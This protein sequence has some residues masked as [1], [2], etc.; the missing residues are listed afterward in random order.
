VFLHEL[1]HAT[2]AWLTCGKVTGM[3]VHP[4]EGGV[5]KTMGGIQ[6][7]ILPAVS[8]SINLQIFKEIF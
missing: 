2:A 6:L 5:T 7:I 1:G 3:E 4:D 8:T